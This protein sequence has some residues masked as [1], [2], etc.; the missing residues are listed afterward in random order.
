MKNHQRKNHGENHAKHPDANR[1]ERPDA[2]PSFPPFRLG[3][4]LPVV[5]NALAV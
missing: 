3:T 1:C 2:A 5:F 4:I